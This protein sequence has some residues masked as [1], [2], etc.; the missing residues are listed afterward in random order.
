[1][2]VAKAYK[3]SVRACN[4]RFGPPELTLAAPG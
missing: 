1:M 2:T 3:R 4:F